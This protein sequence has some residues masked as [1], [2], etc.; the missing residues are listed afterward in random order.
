MVFESCITNYY[1]WNDIIECLIHVLETK[2]DDN[3]VQL[4]MW[5][6]L[7]CVEMIAQLRVGAI[8]SCQ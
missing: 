6:Q 2:D 3:T 1:H 5:V 8:F 4:A 7:T